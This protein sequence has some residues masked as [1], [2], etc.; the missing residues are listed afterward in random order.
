MQILVD[1]DA[2]PV[3]EIIEQIAKEFNIPVTMY[4]DTSHILTS[5]YSSIVTIGQG[6]DA[7]DLA[8]I[9]DSKRGDIIVT[10]DYG[11][12]SLALGKGAFAIHQ[13]GMIYDLSCIDRLLFERHIAK[14]QRKS[15]KKG[16]R[17]RKRTAED[18]IHF[19]T[20]LRQL[21]HS[22]LSSTL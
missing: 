9:N 14:K 19:E 21:I 13:S 4:I 20:A 5:A 1:A 17:N 12:A 6:P 10:Q 16:G 7:V 2:C 3:K 15:G 11:V 8:L 18:D 22:A